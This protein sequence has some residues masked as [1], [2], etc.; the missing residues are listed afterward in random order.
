MA[1]HVLWQADVADFDAWLT[2]F[3]EDE[4]ARKAAGIRDLHV[5]RDPARRDHAVA[6]FEIT[7]LDRATAFLESEELAIHHERG[8]VAHIQVKVLEPV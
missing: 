5:W 4:P 7:D 1:T 6:L 2:V 8:G 3:R